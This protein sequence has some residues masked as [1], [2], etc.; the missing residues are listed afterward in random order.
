VGLEA[1]GEAFSSN[2]ARAAMGLGG[3]D[4]TDDMQVWSHVTGSLRKDLAVTSAWAN[5]HTSAPQ[6]PHVR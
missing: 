2:I 6:W 1:R 3:D 4:A 5:V